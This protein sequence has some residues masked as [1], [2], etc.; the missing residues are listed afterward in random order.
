MMYAY[1]QRGRAIGVLSAIDI[2]LW[3][4]AG[5]LLG[6]PA[7]VLLGGPFLRPDQAL[8]RTV[9]VGT[10]SKAEWRDRAR[11]LRDDPRGFT[12]YK[13]DIHHVL[14]FSSMQQLSPGIGP[15]E[16]RNAAPRV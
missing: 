7:H 14:R 9:E 2:A 16:V 4:L 3:D 12:A 13:I 6:Q 10:L 11:A 15:R 8:P 5:K 1:P